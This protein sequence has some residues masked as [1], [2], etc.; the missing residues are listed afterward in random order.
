MSLRIVIAGG[1]G[2]LGRCLSDE[3][4]TAGHLVS[5]L[6]RRELDVTDR[7]SIDRVMTQVKPDVVINCSAYNAVDAAEADPAT[8]FAVNAS[9]PGHLASACAQAGASIVHYGT[10]FVFDGTSTVPYDEED[11]VHPLSVYG[12]SKL[13][14]ETA[15]QDSCARHYILR[16]ESLFGGVGVAGHRAT[17]DQITERLLEGAPVR[18]VDDRTVSPSYAPDVARATRALIEQSAPHGIYHCVSSGMTTWYEMAKF[19]ASQLEVEGSIERIHASDLKA[20][21]RR[22]QFCALSNRKLRRVG[23]EMSDWQGAVARHL[24]QRTATMTIETT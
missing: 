8:A 1:D 22:P 4:A 10:D 12:A 14:G 24:G 21:A 18:A 15:V 17:I 23:I 6:S 13:A 2:R 19:I 3:L 11:P 9:G 20:P 16:V 5:G 7:E